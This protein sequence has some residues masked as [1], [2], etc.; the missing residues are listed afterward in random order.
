MDQTVLVSQGQA[1]TARLDETKIK[2]RA[3]MWVHQPDTDTWRLWIC[4]NKEVDDKR[5][6]Y[7]LV[8]ETI[9]KH[10]HEL[11]GLDVGTT[12]Y[13]AAGHPAMVGMGRFLKMPGIGSAH[14]SGNRFNNFY[15][16]DGIVIRM[17]L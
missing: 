10:S 8:A 3:V 5:E 12:E 4:P 7:R 15:L 11:S 13:V 6:F 17:D 2:P 1:L 9:S 14:F 16:P